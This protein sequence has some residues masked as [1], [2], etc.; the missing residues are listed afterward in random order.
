MEPSLI[1]PLLPLFLAELVFGL[2]Y[3]WLIHWLGMNGYMKGQTAWSVVVGDAATLFIQWL[4]FRVTWNPFVTLG[5]FAC[6]GLPMVIT[7]LYRYQL[8]VE[9]AKHTR[10]PWPTQALKARSEAMKEIN[11]IIQ[12]LEKAANAGVVNAGTMLSA[13]NKLHL[14]KKILT[15]V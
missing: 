15:S 8:K 6:S 11:M 5:C 3:A 14:I 13:T 1:S 7:Y 12:D 9:K 2:L 4:F 10:R